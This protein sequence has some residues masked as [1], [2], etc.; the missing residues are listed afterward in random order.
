MHPAYTAEKTLAAQYAAGG[1]SARF[2]AERLR[3]QYDMGVY[4][5]HTIARQAVEHAATTTKEAI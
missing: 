5:A 4:E 2:I 3:A 1:A